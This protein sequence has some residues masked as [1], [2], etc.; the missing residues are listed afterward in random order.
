MTEGTIDL[1]RLSLD[2]L[3]QLK[4][5]EEGRLQSIT[6]RYAELRAAHASFAAAKEALVQLTESSSSNNEQPKKMMVP[7]TASLY[8]PGK[9]KDTN[10]FMVDLGTG[11]YVEKSA[12]EA[13][14]FL[15][16]K[17]KLI[18]VNSENIMKAIQQLRHNVESIVMA[19]QGKLVEIRA[20]QEGQRVQRE[21]QE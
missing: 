9:V 17:M 14:E 18:H 13:K 8:V 7:L 15:E 16:R 1:D 19:M 20:R 11:F 12:K 3:N 2:Q 5:Q 4:L 10:K 6:S 21:G